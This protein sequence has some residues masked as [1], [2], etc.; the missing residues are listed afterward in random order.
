MTSFIITITSSYIFPP[1]LS[2]SLSRTPLHQCLIPHHPQKRQTPQLPDITLR[3]T[4][5]RRRRQRPQL[6][7][8]KPAV[9]VR[10]APDFR[11][12]VCTISFDAVP[13][14]VVCCFHI[15]VDG[16]VGAEIRGSG[17]VGAA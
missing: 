12:E 15:G 1:S 14:G 10:P 3:D 11:G 13:E 2:L 4:V 7:K 16:V 17:G 9:R 5:P 6:C 8:L